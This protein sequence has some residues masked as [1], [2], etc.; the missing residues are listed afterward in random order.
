M[1]YIDS[2][3]TSL[4]PD[5]CAGLSELIVSLL[6][7]SLPLH[8]VMATLSTPLLDLRPLLD[9]MRIAASSLDGAQ[10]LRVD[11]SP[12]PQIHRTGSSFP[13]DQRHLLSTVI[14]QRK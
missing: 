10:Q 2:D 14:Y 4:T 3:L 9:R 5:L 11:D 7:V 13:A 6:G 1:I 12:P 8:V